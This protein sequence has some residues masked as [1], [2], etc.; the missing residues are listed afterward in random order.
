MFTWVFA[1]LSCFCLSTR[2][3]TVCSRGSSLSY[4]VFVCLPGSSPCVHVGLR[5]LLL[6]LFVYQDP[7]RVFTWVFAVLSCFC[8]STRILTVCS[9]GS[10]LSYLVFVC[11][12]GSSPCVHVGLRCLILFLFVYQDP[13]RVFTWVFA[14]LSCFCLSTRI[15][16]VCSRGSSLSYLVFVCLP[17]SSPCVHVGLRCLL[18][19]ALYNYVDAN[20]MPSRNCVFIMTGSKM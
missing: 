15:L 9:R 12:P 8:L 19:F 6:F 4:L 5:C 18:H 7:H 2:I 16:T 3:L 20:N 11:L 13:H 10:S 14:V 17:G 1:V